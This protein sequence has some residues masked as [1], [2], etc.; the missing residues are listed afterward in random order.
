MA[1]LEELLE[2]KRQNEKEAERLS[3]LIEQ[4]QSKGPRVVAYYVAL[5]DL[6]NKLKAEAPELLPTP[7]VDMTGPQYPKYRQIADKRYKM[8]ETEIHNSEEDG[9]KAIASLG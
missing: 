1:T 6:I 9:R 3:K 8:S 2:Q 4:E 5:K 7:L